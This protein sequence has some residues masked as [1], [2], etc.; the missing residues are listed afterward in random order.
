MGTQAGNAVSDYSKVWCCVALTDIWTGDS[1]RNPNRLIT[2][3]LLG[4]I[5][6]WC[7]VLVRGLGGSAC[8][9]SFEDR[10]TSPSR[11]PEPSVK[12][13]GE[14]GHHCVVCELFGCTG[15]A[16]KF[17]FDVLGPDGKPQPDQIKK[18]DR[19]RLVFT[20][21]RPTRNEEWALL[22]VTIRLIANYG[23]IGG[24]TVYKPSD[25][26]GR[27]DAAH[28]RDYGIV[29]IEQLSGVDA[30]SLEQLQ[31]HVRDQRWWR[32]NHGAFA[33][34]SLGTFWSV[35]GRYLARQD[36]NRST[37]NQVIG[38]PEP[39]GQ[40]SQGDSWLAGRRA[41][42]WQHPESKKVFSIKNPPRTFGFTNGNQLSLDAIKTKLRRV[43]P[44]L[45]DAE[46]RTSDVILK[47]LCRARI[48]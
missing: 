35:T 26:N 27:Q 16:R 25:E 45:E 12:R 34:A 46:L 47:E 44:D 4:S 32:V 22:D 42:G 3:G 43:W 8:D 33:W 24:K 23:A 28:H 7:E 15:W 1:T 48:A 38:R 29:S 18:D 39:K 13:P 19:F 20:P 31:A 30:V 11:C 37:F 21:I 6:W 2:T 40:A 10:R 5:R 17:R 41:S 36:A 14:P 9:P